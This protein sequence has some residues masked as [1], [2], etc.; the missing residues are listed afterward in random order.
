MK[1]IDFSKLVYDPNVWNDARYVTPPETGNYE[2]RGRGHSYRISGYWD[3][4]RWWDYEPEEN[5]GLISSRTI[6]VSYFTQW[7]MTKFGFD[8]VTREL[9]KQMQ[10]THEELTLKDVCSITGYKDIEAR[11]MMNNLTFFGHLKSRKVDGC[12][13]YSLPTLPEQAA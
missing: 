4:Q 3:G 12:L 9:L 8:F 11:R 5:Q 1:K 2:V 10:E 6:Q 13:V 7:R